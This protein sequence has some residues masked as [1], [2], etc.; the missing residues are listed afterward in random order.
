MRIK[1]VLTQRF[2]GGDGLM[3]TCDKQLGQSWKDEQK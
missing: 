1:T 2:T 3:L